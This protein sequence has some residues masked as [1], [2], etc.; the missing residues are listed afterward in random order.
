MYILT[1]DNV[2]FVDVFGL[3]IYIARRYPEDFM[4]IYLFPQFIWFS[5]E[6]L[7]HSWLPPEAFLHTLVLQKAAPA[8]TAFYAIC[9]LCDQTNLSGLSLM[10]GP[11][12]EAM[13][14][15]FI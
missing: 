14:P 8:G 2:I 7:K 10:P 9:I 6:V 12:V 13:V 1:S 11:M 3:S 15:L 5:A 4:H